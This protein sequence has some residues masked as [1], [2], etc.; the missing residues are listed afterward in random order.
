VP[1]SAARI[2]KN[3]YDAVSGTQVQN[4]I[5]FPQVLLH[6]GCEQHG[7]H[8]EAEQLLILDDPAAVPLEIIQ[9]LSGF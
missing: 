5:P 2:Q 6:K 4:I 1:A 9:P 3:R 8:P 7:I